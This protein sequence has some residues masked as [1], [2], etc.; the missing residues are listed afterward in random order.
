MRKP[1]SVREGIDTATATDAH[2]VTYSFLTLAQCHLAAKSP[3][4]GWVWWKVAGEGSEKESEYFH[5]DCVSTLPGILEVVVEHSLSVYWMDNS[6]LESGEGQIT[7]I[8]PKLPPFNEEKVTLEVYWDATIPAIANR[9]SEE[10]HQHL[11]SSLKVYPHELIRLKGITVVRPS[12]DIKYSCPVINSVFDE[13]AFSAAAA[14]D[15]VPDF[16]EVVRMGDT[17]DSRVGIGDLAWRDLG[18]SDSSGAL[19]HC[20]LS[21]GP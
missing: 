19:C 12:V 18:L 4:Q 17:D 5:G 9:I 10:L 2:N 3:F 16:Y 21:I 14:G 1:R 8:G 6:K 15:V 11:L 13:A 7:H 20:C